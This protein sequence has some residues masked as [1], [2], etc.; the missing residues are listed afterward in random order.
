MRLAQ[1]ILILLNFL[2]VEGWVGRAFLFK[3][4]NINNHSLIHLQRPYTVNF[5]NLSYVA[6]QPKIIDFQIN[7]AT[8]NNEQKFG[9]YVNIQKV[10]TDP[11][12]HITVLMDSGNEHFDL[13]YLNRTFNICEFLKNNKLNVF[14]A[15][16][17]QILSQ[18]VEMPKQCPLLKVTS[19]IRYFL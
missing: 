8:V 12:I 18:Y 5:R 16:V 4:N 15:I 10:L 14:L 7:I 1:T 9:G 2:V 17:H 3:K 6:L 13:I 19:H 11:Y